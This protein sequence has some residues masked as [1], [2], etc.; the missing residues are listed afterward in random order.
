[1][2]KK[3]GDILGFLVLFLDPRIEL[4]AHLFL[5]TKGRRREALRTLDLGCKLC[6]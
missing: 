2:G 5:L 4:K 6:S 3:K 1:V